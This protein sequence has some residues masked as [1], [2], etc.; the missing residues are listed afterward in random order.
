MARVS[1]SQMRQRA[2]GALAALRAASEHPRKGVRLSRRQIAETLGLSEQQA[3]R[4][5]KLLEK[6]GLVEVVSN[7]LPNGGQ[8][9]NTYRLTKKGRKLLRRAEADEMLAVAP[10]AG[11]A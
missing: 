9:E 4:V 6:E 8:I 1:D 10:G 2:M 11:S 5:M 7:F 3:R